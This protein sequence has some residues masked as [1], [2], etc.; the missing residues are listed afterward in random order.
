[1]V[2]FKGNRLRLCCHLCYTLWA[3]CLGRKKKVLRDVEGHSNHW[4]EQSAL[5]SGEALGDKS[6]RTVRGV[7]WLFWYVPALGYQPACAAV[8]RD[9]AVTLSLTLWLW[10]RQGRGG[11]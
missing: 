6:H 5:P 7:G 2:T 8:H 3:P 4:S 11:H 10:P 9:S 1:M